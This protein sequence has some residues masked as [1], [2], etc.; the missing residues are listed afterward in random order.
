MKL[1]S[2]CLFLL[3]VADSLV[4]TYVFGAEANPYILWHMGFF[5]LTLGQAMAL[6]VAYC[7]PF[8]LVLDRFSELSKMVFILYATIW[9]VSALWAIGCEFLI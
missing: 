9:G 6:R 7:L 2:I 3:I 8:V 1:W 5:G 4:T